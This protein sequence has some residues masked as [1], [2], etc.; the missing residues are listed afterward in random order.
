MR[1][2]GSC[3]LLAAFI[4]VSAA[5]AASGATWH[6]YADGSGDAA[7]IKA[8][9]GL[10]AAGDSVVVFA[11]TYNEHDINV[12]KQLF[13]VSVAGETS[14]IID[15]QT[16]GRCFLFD[17]FTP[18]IVIK[19]FTLRNADSKYT[20][21]NPGSGGAVLFKS[22]SRVDMIDCAFR[23]NSA[24]MGGA[25][26]ARDSSTVTFQRC[27]F[28][29]NVAYQ[30][31]YPGEG[32]AV[33]LNGSLASSTALSAVFDSCLF[34]N[35]T[36]QLDG[37]AIAMNRCLPAISHST[38]YSNHAS[39][40]G[41]TISLVSD[42]YLTMDRTI[43][44]F[45]D[46]YGIVAWANLLGAEISCCDVYSNP[47][48]NY[49]GLIPNQTG[50]NYNISAD[51]WF[52]SAPGD[53]SIS[54]I[55][56][57]APAH[58]SCGELIGRYGP[59]CD[60]GPNLIVA[61][62]VWSSTTPQPGTTVTGTVKVK[63]VGY[64]FTGAFYIDYYKDR[65]GTPPVGLA[66]DERHL[67]SSLAVGDSV[68]W[69]IS[70]VSSA[71]F[72][73]WHSY[74]QV[75]TDDDVLEFNE[76]DN[77]SGP[78][79]IAWQVPGESGWPVVTGG[80]FHSSPVIAPIDGDPLTLEVAIG[81]DDGKLYAWN[82]NGT[83]LP[84]F[85]VTLPDS[86]VSSPAV[87]DVTGDS[88]NEI[89]VGCNDGALYVYNCY[90]TKLWYY[91]TGSPVRTTPCLA[92]LDGDGK[93]EIICASWS[94]VH[95]LRGNGAVYKGW[96]YEEDVRFAG[97]AVGDVDGDGVIEIAA[98]ARVNDSVSRVYLFEPGGELHSGAWP[99]ALDGRVT[100]GPAL[101]DFLAS[102]S[103]LEIVVGDN[104]G[105]IHVIGETGVPWGTM[106]QVLGS[107]ASPPILEDTDFDGHL[108]IVAASRLLTYMGFPPIPAWVG[109]VTAIDHTGAVAAG[110][111]NDTGKWPNDV[112]PLPSP[113]ALG[114]H[115]D[116]M[117]G[118]PANSLYS[119]YGSGERTPAFPLS[120]GAG[121]IT[122]A[123][124]GDIDN[125]EWVE[126]VVATSAGNVYCRELRSYNYSKTDLWWPM[127][128]HDRART[129]CY[130]FDVPTD[131]DENPAVPT[132]TALGSIYPNPFNPTTTITF[133]LSAKGR[134]EIAIYDVSGRKLAV[135]VDRELDAGR[136]EVL[137]NG[138]TMGGKTAAAGI[139][140]CTLR[141]AGVSETKK[142][143]LLR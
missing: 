5:V 106:P 121:I 7:T 18:T 66:G 46:C 15:A 63:N 6:I 64:W 35:N 28:L 24:N 101:G 134:A 71:V 11:G 34:V 83:A 96:P 58:S 44:S 38:F 111:P 85:P 125:D 50:T 41:G 119:W 118:S 93:L 103:G 56:P 92:D 97:A 68:S 2:V 8:A 108:E 14:T 25:A 40:G 31:N 52:C 45:S 60:T 116:A 105:I 79:T 137:W 61:S 117:C 39:S 75:D 110:W 16:L 37:A 81:C 4:V 80:G 33:N 53:L 70:P 126:L 94:A 13:I 82:A 87:G 102:S 141:A 139:Y 22:R 120:F 17:K 51:P 133:D 143:V 112:G 91:A 62:V 9:V 136:H 132:V 122:S 76:T 54:T 59:F 49:G 29:D 30:D 69:T 90:G 55:S 12:T 95:V 3:G 135:L 27:S 43:V 104:S 109:Y 26:M 138:K 1:Q 10:A 140:F 99:V 123:A 32:G 142:L 100:A 131:V 23:S 98:A 48:G 42:V 36:A 128:G 130:G 89:V 77:V 47:S 19:G 78:H 74:F 73:E 115:T 57:C 129:H 114:T 21:A 88:R 127:Y 107:I 124:A 113:V 86:I 72:G 84:G 67:V 65:A 20:A